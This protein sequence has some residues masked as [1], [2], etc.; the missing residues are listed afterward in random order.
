MVN[1]LKSLFDEVTCASVFFPTPILLVDI[2]HSPVVAECTSKANLQCAT[3]SIDDFYLQ[4][5]DLNSFSEK[6]KHNPL[7][8]V[9]LNACILA[10]ET[11]S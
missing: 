6:H 1:S 4:H 7:F 9:N 8:E 3:M 10:N 11:P 2:R 5:D